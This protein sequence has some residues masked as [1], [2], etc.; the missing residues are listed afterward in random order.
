MQSVSPVFSEKEVEL[1]KVIAL[2]QPEYVPLIGLPVIYPDGLR[3]VAVRFRLTEE[4]KKLVADGGDSLITEL[5]FGGKFTPISIWISDERT[6]E[7]GQ[8]NPH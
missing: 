5:T 6:D 3:G 2:D 7:N 4:E 1:E 8:P